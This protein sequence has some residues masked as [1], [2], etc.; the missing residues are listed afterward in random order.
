[1]DVTI[2]YPTYPGVVA[3]MMGMNINLDLM[4]NSNDQHAQAVSF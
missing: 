3:L 2:M 1:M 4:S